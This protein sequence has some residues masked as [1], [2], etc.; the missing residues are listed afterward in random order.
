MQRSTHRIAGKLLTLDVA[1]PE[2][3]ETISELFARWYV[4]PADANAPSGTPQISV[5]GGPRP[6]IPPGGLTFEVAAGDCCYADAYTYVVDLGAIVVKVE[7]T[8]AEAVI[9][10]EDLDVFDA[11]VMRDAVMY[12]V[13][14][15]L[16][17]S[18][19]YD[20]HCGALVHP[21]TGK[22]VLLI[23]PSGSGKSTLAVHLASAGW[24]FLSDDVVVLGR[25]D[26]E[27][28]AW[29]VRR[30]FA[31]TAGTLAASEVVRPVVAPGP[32]A[33]PDTKY[34]FSP[35]EVFAG[36]FRE[37]CDPATLVF[38]SLTGDARSR[39]ERLERL[40]AMTRLIRMSPWSCYDRAVAADHLAVLS[41]LNAQA[42]SFSLLAGTDLLERDAAVALLAGA[43]RGE[44]V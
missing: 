39:L 6:S 21:D 41:D 14:A 23:G 19:R 43:C 44:H 38:T 31:I 25:D 30:G 32:A 8:P 5:R 27:I 17:R 36:G 20:L 15:V 28:S 40:D 11:A 9:W 42:S 33:D 24:P 35:H 2:P 13:S 29:P 3:A 26:E 18:Q 1:A 37:R 16:R 12:A 4:F 7:G 10:M 22:G 34:L